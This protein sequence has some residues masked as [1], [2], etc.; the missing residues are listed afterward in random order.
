[1]TEFG[2]VTYTIADDGTVATTLDGTDDGTE[3]DSTIT[4][5][6]WE[7][8]LKTEL[9]LNEDTKLA[10][11]ITGD[12]HDVGTAMVA[13]IET[14]TEAGTEVIT[15]FGT[16]KAADVG[17]DDGTFDQATTANPVSGKIIT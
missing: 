10:E 4:T 8:I 2:N 14:Y 3:E 1:V 11:T 17:Y 13:G 16:V 9:D 7:A 12:A 15:E 6:G 5:E